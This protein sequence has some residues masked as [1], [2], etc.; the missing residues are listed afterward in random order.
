MLRLPWLYREGKDKKDGP[1]PGETGLADTGQ[2]RLMMRRVKQARRNGM[3]SAEAEKGELD[4]LRHGIRVI[5]ASVH[6]DVGIWIP[7]DKVIRPRA[8]SRRR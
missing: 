4:Q 3:I 6:D 2:L 5:E 1:R 7:K 8:R